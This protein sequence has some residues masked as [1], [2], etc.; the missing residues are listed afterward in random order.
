ND[1][2][3]LRIEEDEEEVWKF[4]GEGGKSTL[5][6]EHCLVAC[7]LTA[8]VVQKHD[9]PHCFFSEGIAKQF[10]DFLGKF[11]EYDTKHIGGVFRNYMRIR[12]LIDVRIPLKRRKRIMASCSKQ[13]YGKFKYEKLTLFCFLCGCLGHSDKFCPIRLREWESELEIG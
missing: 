4:N 13:F 1:L 2:A 3:R 8:N 5:R 10:R 11:M 12:V 7:F 6:Y 9:L